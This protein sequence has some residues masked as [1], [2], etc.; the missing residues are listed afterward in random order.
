MLATFWL[1]SLSSF[2]KDYRPLMTILVIIITKHFKYQSL[3][4]KSLSTQAQRLCYSMESLI[5]DTLCSLILKRKL[6][7]NSETHVQS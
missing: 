3:I 1:I 4:L 5:Q 6:K 2:H 7:K